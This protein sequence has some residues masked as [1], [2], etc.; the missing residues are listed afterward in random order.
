[1]ENTKATLVDNPELLEEITQKVVDRLDGKTEE[2]LTE[3]AVE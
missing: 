1:M 2:A 3:L